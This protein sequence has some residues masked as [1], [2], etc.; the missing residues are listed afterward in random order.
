MAHKMKYP[1]G[2]GFPFKE[3]ESPLKDHVPGHP[4]LT[5]VLDEFNP[6]YY[7]DEGNYNPPAP[8][9]DPT[10]DQ[11]GDHIIGTPADPN[12]VPET[13]T[14][15]ALGR[16][17]N[18]ENNLSAGNY[19]NYETNEETGEFENVQ[20]FTVL[21]DETTLNWHKNGGDSGATV[22]RF[23]GLGGGDSL[24]NPS[25]DDHAKSIAQ[26]QAEHRAET[27]QHQWARGGFQGYPDGDGDSGGG[28]EDDFLKPNPDYTDQWG[29]PVSPVNDPKPNI[30]TFGNVVSSIHDSP[31]VDSFGNPASPVNPGDKPDSTSTT[32]DSLRPNPDPINDSSRPDVSPANNSSRPNVSPVATDIFGNEVNPVDERGDRVPFT[33]NTPATFA[34]GRKGTSTK[35]NRGFIQPR[36][37]KK[38]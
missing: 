8:E 25:L 16:E 21:D 34:F 14:V 31:N 36:N 37:Y 26:R 22:R 29:N 2:K 24:I 20:G 10:S 7:D 27:G 18:E 3:K 32:S 13:T 17:V 9:H 33:V 35:G 30:D 23:S 38:I 4:G 1:K 15:D 5:D 12:Y 11:W 6:L 19:I 28:I